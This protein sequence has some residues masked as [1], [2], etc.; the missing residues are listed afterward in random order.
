MK[1]VLLLSVCA[2][3]L[4]SFGCERNALD[5]V[6]TVPDKYDANHLPEGVEGT[7]YTPNMEDFAVR[8]RAEDFITIPAGSVDALADAIDAAEIGGIIY[9]EA[10]VHT[11]TSRLTITKAVNIIGED[12]ALI[13]MTNTFDGAMVDPGIR[14][15]AAGTVIQNVEIKPK[16]PVGWTA[17]YIENASN[18]AILSCLISSFAVGIIVENS[19]QVAIIDNTIQDC[20]FFSVLPLSGLSTYIGSNYFSGSGGS[21]VWANDKWGTIENNVFTENES[22][23]LL[24]NFPEENGIITPSGAPMGAVSTATGW[25]LRT[26]QFIDNINIGISVRDGAR[27]NLIEASNQYSGNG[28]YDIRIPADEDVPGFIFIPAAVDNT[29]YA[30]PEVTIKD[31]GINTTIIGGTIVD[32]PC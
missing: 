25:K 2:L 13:E 27:W 20:S 7:Y 15:Q 8:Q 19:D 12:D 5:E 17:I 18:S 4:F 21:S 24:C 22:G 10:G 29:I 9:L 14:V 16:S 1:N 11:L 23:I 6:A 26:N 3:V 31:C 28:Q 30:A 32:D